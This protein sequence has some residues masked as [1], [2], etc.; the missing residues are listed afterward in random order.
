[1][2]ISQD[3]NSKEASRGYVF[4]TLTNGEDKNID[5]HVESKNYLY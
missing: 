1:M 3:S 2:Y 5:F 4:T